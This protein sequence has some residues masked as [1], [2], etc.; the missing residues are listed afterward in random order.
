ME[1][2]P[3]ESLNRRLGFKSASMLGR[4][5]LLLALSSCLLVSRGSSPRGRPM[6]S[7]S[8]EQFERA[9]DPDCGRVPIFEKAYGRSINETFPGAPPSGDFRILHGL[10]VNV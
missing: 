4:T 8:S 2:L 5:G 6:E 7:L 1:H 9:L 3:I 10:D